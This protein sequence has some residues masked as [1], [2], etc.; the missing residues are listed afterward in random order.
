M[1]SKILLWLTKKQTSRIRHKRIPLSAVLLLGVGLTCLQAQESTHTAG[2]NASGNGGS[3]S[4]SVGQTTYHI[5]SG[6][7]GSVAEGVQQPFE[8]SVI[9][10]VEEAKGITLS[11]SVYPNP[12]AGYLI[13]EVKDY[14]FSTL[15]FHLYDLQGRLLQ[16]KKVTEKRTSIALSHYSP[17]IYFV[18]VTSGKNEI[19]TFRVVK[20]QEE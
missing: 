14:E 12:A 6:T 4:Y 2:G 15:Y 1:W 19:K 5:H 20:M 13:L 17:S 18:K 11:A 3:V 7:T 8:I 10:G 9:S 16:N